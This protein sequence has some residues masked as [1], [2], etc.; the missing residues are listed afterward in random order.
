MNKKCTVLE[1]GGG[2]KTPI[3]IVNSLVPLDSVDFCSRIMDYWGIG[4]RVWMR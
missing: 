1:I 2:K 3:V 4:T